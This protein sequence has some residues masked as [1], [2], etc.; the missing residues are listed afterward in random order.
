MSGRPWELLRVPVA[1]VCVLAAQ[2]PNAQVPER[3][4]GVCLGVQSLCCGV[5]AMCL[6]EGQKLLLELGW[7]V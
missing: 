3:G 6:A 2:E 5:K 7:A 1:S 4:P